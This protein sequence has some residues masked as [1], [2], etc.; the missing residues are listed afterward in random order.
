[1][2]K[3]F[4]NGK[5]KKRTLTALSVALAA[6]LTMGVLSACTV[7]E[8]EPED[9]DSVVA[10]T[11]TQLLR[12]GNF[13]FYS[14]N[15]LSDVL[16][17]HNVI[18]SPNNW[19]FTSGSPSSDTASGIINTAEWD[20]Y[21]KSGGHKF[22]TYTKGEGDD[23]EEV[24]TFDSIADAYAHWEDDDVNAYDRIKFLDIYKDEISELSSSSDEAKLFAKYKYSV[25]FEDIEKFAED[26]SGAPALRSGVKEDETS[27]LM[28]HNSRDT[29]GVRGTAQ[30]YTSSTTITLSAGT[31][32]KVSVWV[33]TDNLVHYD[34]VDLT[35]RGG[36]YIGV[37]NTV[38]GN[39]L[40]QMQIYNINTRGEWQEYTVYVRASTFATSTFRIVLG[41]GQGSSDDRYY[42]VDGYAF[43]DDVSCEII[44]NAD[45]VE[46]VLDDA[47]YNIPKSDIRLCTVD[48][49]KAEKQFDTDSV[50]E[51]TFALDLY[52]GFEGDTKL[53]GQDVK[54]G[55]TEEKSG[56]NTYDSARIDPSLKDDRPE[57][58]EA[59]GL[60]F[61][62]VTTLGEIASS[63]TSNPYLKNVYENDL[64]DKFPFAEDSGIVMLM[65]ANGAAYT[66]KLNP[67]TLAKGERMLISFFAKTNSVLSG[68][69]GGSAVVV[70]GEN[71]T[72]LSSFDSTTI[73]TT[74]ID[75]KS[76]DESKKDIYKGWIQ[77]FF[78]LENDTD[79]E[80]TFHVELTF[81]PTTI[82]G[83]NK[84]SYGDGYAAFTNFETKLLTKTEYGYA[85][86]GDR[87]KKVSLTGE[88]T[89]N[90]KFDSV[91]AT[92]EK[93]IE[94]GLA[95]PANFRGVK[96]GSNFVMEGGDEN[97]KPKHVYSGLLSSQY[98]ENYYSGDDSEWKDVLDRAAGTVSG[99][100]E[101][102]SKLFGNAR[103][104]LVIVNKDAASYGYFAERSSVSANSY[105]R[106]SL[107][108]KASVG[109]VAYIYLT[110]VSD[111]KNPGARLTPNLPNYT[112]WYD[113]E[114]NIVSQDPTSDEYD[115]DTDILFE[116]Q[117]NGLYKK[118]GDNS[119]TYYA[120][121]HNFDTDSDGNLVTKDGEIVYF[122]DGGKFYAYRDEKSNG[123]YSY[124]T[125]VTNLPTD[126]A[127][128]D[129]SNKANIPTSEMIV[130]GT[131]EWVTVNFYVHTGNTAKNYRLEVWS[132]SREGD[133]TNPKD[134]YVFFDNYSSASAS[135]N[136]ST[137]LAET[138]QAIKDDYN[139][140]HGYQLG[141]KEYIGVN[142]DLPEDYENAKYYTFTFFDSNT[143]V[144]YDETMD[145]DE[146]G[147]PWGSYLQSNYSKQLVS[148]FYKN[149]GEAASSYN[150]FLDYSA[151]EVTVTPDDLS[152]D[153]DTTTDDTH[154]RLDTDTNIF[155][156]I[157][158]GGMAIVLLAVI[159][160]LVIRRI[161]EA[162]GKKKRVKPVKDKRVRSSKA[163]PASETNE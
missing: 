124:R 136:Y 49:V 26:F 45:Y 51:K 163:K 157:A 106:I 70:D 79:N 118:V 93:T 67:L 113:D 43:F 139:D 76:D 31:S 121:L 75:S 57:A 54:I 141:D 41:L 152:V 104:P 111:A 44:S 2:A 119:D 27:V 159:L 109:A 96:G 114:G 91:S 126:I 92:D 108:V 63:S 89:E 80:K 123:E 98:A 151:I 30:Y 19:T 58:G 115:E 74:D 94:N 117:E 99:A 46:A 77:C 21:T 11:D 125:P 100:D 143:Y 131:G 73:S 33:R 23:A 155:L 90:K 48:S 156:L 134:S 147:N 14:D 66:A 116:L 137:I 81:G 34:G 37:T 25:D 153:D 7:K 55:L 110:D 128:Y 65:S 3:F 29:D 78:F 88:V 122:L 62:K 162:V 95:L 32:A 24:T 28:I 71:K 84:F 103:Q 13:E 138:L 4:E 39:T 38:G 18:S 132:G 85:S 53:L 8:D 140:K 129:Y 97:I 135:S 50:T 102:W 101:W 60:N 68:L 150:F 146:L 105:Q 130:E 82:V 161:I 5:W 154:S 86:T 22:K 127:R 35:A 52:A 107:R 47:D 133:V 144:R 17:K 64:K 56:S 20:Y 15:N 112:Y 120:N 83:T 87:A 72:Y 145:E 12:N 6:T 59:N 142:D 1:M 10:P 36:A 149:E 69:V 42:S 158:S 16:K 148:L 160:I 61:A 9:E 40:D